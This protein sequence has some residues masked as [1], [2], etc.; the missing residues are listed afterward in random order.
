MNALNLVANGIIGSTQD[1][2]R[3]KEEET[4][5]VLVVGDTHSSYSALYK[6]VLTYGSSSSALIFTGDGITDLCTLLTHATKESVLLQALPPLIFFVK[7]NN[8]SSVYPAHFLKETNSIL[9]L[10]SLIIPHTLTFSIARHTVFLTHGAEYG[11]YYSKE[12][13]KAEAR[14][15]K[16]Q[17]VIFGHTHCP[18]E[19]TGGVYYL[20][21]GSIG[22]PRGGFKSGFAFL[23]IVKRQ[24]YST[25]YKEVSR[26]HHE[27]C[28]YTPYS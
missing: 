25:F 28:Q 27:Y 8:D 14:Y 5:S 16:A 24:I 7:G 15:Y 11:V 18:E 20:N 17:I 1:Y 12:E 19:R 22:Y 6:I 23:Q 3:L 26:T 2:N 10:T 4:A 13:L 21:P 9:N